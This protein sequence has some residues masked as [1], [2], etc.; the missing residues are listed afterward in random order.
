MAVA[1]L[2]YFGTMVTAL[3]GLM[4]LLNGFLTSPMMERARPHPYPRPVVEDTVAAAAPNKSAE[5]TAAQTQAASVEQTRLAATNPAGAAEKGKRPKVA[6]DQTRNANRDR[7][8]FAENT[9]RKEDMAGRRQ[10]QEYTARLGYAQEAQQAVSA[11]LFDFF[12]TR[13]F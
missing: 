7:R 4:L 13:R 1:L 3:A 8:T 9:S 11:P 5:A 12:Q 2:A 10:D 6:R